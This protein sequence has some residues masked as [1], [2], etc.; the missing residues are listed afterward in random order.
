M[1]KLRIVAQVLNGS[2]GE[3]REVVANVP[4]DSE[5]DAIN[6]LFARARKDDYYYRFLGDSGVIEPSTDKKQPI[7]YECNTYWA[8]EA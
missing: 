1:N 8:L 3:I 5:Q 6:K 4:A 2:T 7:H